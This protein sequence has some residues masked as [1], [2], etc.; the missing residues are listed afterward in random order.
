MQLGL[1]IQTHTL[2]YY[3]EQSSF[4]KLICGEIYLYGLQTGTNDTSTYKNISMMLLQDCKSTKQWS[5]LEQLTSTSVSCD[6]KDGSFTFLSLSLFLFKAV[7]G[8]SKEH[9]VLFAL[10]LTLQ[11]LKTSA[12]ETQDIPDLSHF[13]DCVSP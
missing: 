12:V 9:Y 1:S 4:S 6:C 13:R 7:C 8:I 5:L 10:N 3:K 2:Q 11:E